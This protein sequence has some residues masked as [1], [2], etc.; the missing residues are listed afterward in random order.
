MTTES[1]V[2][3]AMTPTRERPWPDRNIRLH[4]A[5]QVLLG[6]VLA[7]R[8]RLQLDLSF[9]WIVVMRTY[10]NHFPLSLYATLMMLHSTFGQ[11]RQTS[12]SSWHS[13]SYVHY[14]L[15]KRA[16]INIPSMSLV[17]RDVAIHTISYLSTYKTTSDEYR[18]GLSVSTDRTSSSCSTKQHKISHVSVFQFGLCLDGGMHHNLLD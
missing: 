4:Y 10:L 2:N 18:T 13:E 1:S 5:G 14:T 3:G 12:N 16:A 7:V 17:R 8:L 11:C 15:Y 9:G 6:A